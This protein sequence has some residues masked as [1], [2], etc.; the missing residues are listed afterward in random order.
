MSSTNLENLWQNCMESAIQGDANIG[1]LDVTTKNIHLV[2][3]FTQSRF[4]KSPL[5]VAIMNANFEWIKDMLEKLGLQP[6]LEEEKTEKEEVTEENEQ[7]TDVNS[8]NVRPSTLQLAI[9]WGNVEIVRLLVEYGAKLDGIDV[10]KLENSE[11]KE[12]L[13]SQIEGNLVPCYKVDAKKKKKK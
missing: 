11:I 1:G 4:K 2:H 10:E 8:E 12:I 3:Q 13:E 7:T 6:D 9:S 5:E